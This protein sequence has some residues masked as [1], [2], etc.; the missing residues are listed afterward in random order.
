MAHD[1]SNAPSPEP[2]GPRIRGQLSRR[3]SY[4]PIRVLAV[5]TG[6]ALVRGVLS[7][8]GRY[9]L[10]LRREATAA[11]DGGTMTLDVEW[12][13]L[14][15]RF[16]R[17]RTVAP[18]RTIDAARFEDRR[19]YVYLLVG[20]G[21]L[22]IGTWIGIQWLVEGLRAG[23]PQLALIGAGIVAAGVLL[24]LAMYVFVPEGK[25]RS[26]VHLILGPWRVRLAGVEREAGERFLEALREGWKS[27]SP[28]R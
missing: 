27:A 11:I 15:R 23:F 4:A 9:L 12:S 20:F 16:R 17:I 13:I 8:V 26:R 14:G 21:C 6:F 25:G 28:G 2:A 5:L 18:I 1:F 3:L 22:A 19:R 24:D 7:L 10:V